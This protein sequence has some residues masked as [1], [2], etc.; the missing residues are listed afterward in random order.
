MRASK[1]HTGEAHGREQGSHQSEFECA[2][3][4]PH[5]VTHLSLPPL[6]SMFSIE[7]MLMYAWYA[8]AI[9]LGVVVYRRSGV[10]KDHEYNRAKAMR[11]IKHVY[12][13]EESWCL[14]KR[15]CA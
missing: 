5:G 4:P 2:A 13:A 12:E 3:T 7:P 1:D 10:V 14:V 9:L 11:K 8:V 15:R 6:Q